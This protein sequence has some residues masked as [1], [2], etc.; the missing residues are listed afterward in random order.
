MASSRLACL[1]V[2]LFPLAARLRSEPE[3]RRE[4]LVI[5]EGNGAAARVIAASRSARKAGVHPGT[6]LAQARSKIP[7]L[8]AR[9][10]DPE[11]ERSAQE[12][13]LEIAEQFSPRV[14]DLGEGELHLDVRGLE[15]HFPGENPEHQLGCALRKA[16]EQLCLPARIGI[17]S[18]KLAAFVAAGVTPSPTVVADGEE[19]SFLAP[20]SL[21]SLATSAQTLEVLRGWGIR[22]IGDLADL[23]R[24]EVSS[25][26]GR[27]GQEL[28]ALAR[29][30]DPVP[31]QPRQ[32]PPGFREGLCLEWAVVALEPFLFVARTALERLV[33]RLRSRGLACQSLTLDLELEPEGHHQFRIDLPAPSCDVKT[34][35]TLTRLELEA[36]S[37]GAPILSFSFTAHPDRP[38]EA[39]LTLFGPAALSPD[40]LATTLAKLFA[41]LGPDRIGS[42]RVADNHRPEAFQLVDFRAPAPPSKPLLPPS[43]GRGLLAIR[44]LR[45][46][47][48]LEVLLAEPS[49]LSSSSPSSNRFLSIRS[50]AQD[51]ATS[52]PQ[53]QGGVRVAAG[54]WSLEDDWWTAV[55]TDRKYWDVELDNGNLYRIYQDS[56]THQWLADGIYD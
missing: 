9:S 2:P 21:H 18:S 23:S 51:Q 19:A 6:T 35:L 55:P 37:P 41:F 24:H 10:R 44:S 33:E 53:I 56:E 31:F 22:T 7:Q 12:S 42:P 50:K 49:D 15:L 38:R 29:G 13:L 32:P 27:S 28:H 47:V 4:S 3:L 45:P 34:L 46:P 48:E 16:T 26:L 5:L 25:R 11:C 52:R 1:R 39:Q 17:A 30:Q 20:L 8:I 40:R 14:E 36:R 43:R 54:P